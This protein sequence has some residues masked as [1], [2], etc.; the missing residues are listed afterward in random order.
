[1][2]TEDEIKNMDIRSKMDAN[3]RKIIRALLEGDT[4][5]IEA[6]KL[7]QATLRAMLQ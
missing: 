7:A 6:H 2:S 4:A 3:D 5:R 1:M